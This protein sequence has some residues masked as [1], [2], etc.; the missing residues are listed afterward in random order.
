MPI[1][2]GLVV[3]EISLLWEYFF[4]DKDLMRSLMHFIIVELHKDNKLYFNKMCL[5]NIGIL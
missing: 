5:T 1:S 2:R 4:S 3:C